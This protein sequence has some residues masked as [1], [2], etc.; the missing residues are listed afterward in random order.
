[1]YCNCQH[2]LVTPSNC[3][4]YSSDHHLLPSSHYLYRFILLR[5]EMRKKMK[6]DL[7]LNVTFFFPLTCYL[8][9]LSVFFHCMKMDCFFF[10]LPNFNLLIIQF[11]TSYGCIL[12]LYTTTSSSSSFGD[13]TTLRSGPLSWMSG[14]N[15]LLRYIVFQTLHVYLKKNMHSNANKHKLSTSVPWWKWHESPLQRLN[16]SWLWSQRTHITSKYSCIRCS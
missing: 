11:N 1:M 14:S 8:V 12:Q 7:K 9:I 3:F 2:T 5:E 10:F 13:W 16:T 15:I 6:C 4:F